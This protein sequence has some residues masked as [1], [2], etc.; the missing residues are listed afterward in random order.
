MRKTIRELLK[1]IN[2]KLFPVK[3][4][5]AHEL[6]Y[7]KG[8]LEKEGVLSNDHYKYFY[9]EFFDLEEEFYRNKCILDI[10]CGPRGSL[11][12]A[13]MA[14]ERVGLDPLA[15]EYLKLGAD[16]HAMTYIDAPSEQIPFSD[17]H[18]DIVCSFNSL[19]HVFDV[20]QTLKEI[21]R[22]VKPGG[23]FLL[24][25]EVNHSSTPT[26]PIV[27]GWDIVETLSD[28]FEIL[29]VKQFEIGNHSIYNQILQNNVFDKS[30]LTDRPGILT[31]KLRKNNGL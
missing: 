3:F 1:H 26:E 12:W 13:S 30:D 21:K 25:V 23:Y 19:D 5:E 10:G 24:I 6:A 2:R 27:L 14:H 22:I 15:K 9:L 8:C 16:K 17:Q 4:K 7:W 20:H 28:D 18:F 31:A 11:E 29:D